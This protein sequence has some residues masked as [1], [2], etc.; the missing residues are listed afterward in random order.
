[1]CCIS[2][3]ND[4][5]PKVCSGIKVIYKVLAVGLSIYL[6]VAAIK[7]YQTYDQRP[8][9]TFLVVGNGTN[10]SNGQN[11]SYYMIR[12]GANITNCS[13]NARFRTDVSAIYYLIVGRT[14]V[15]FVIL[16]VFWFNLSVAIILILLD[17]YKVVRLLVKC[18]PKS[19]KVFEKSYESS[20]KAKESSTIWSVVDAIILKLWLL[21][22]ITAP[23]Y[24]VSAF[25]YSQICLQYQSE[26]DLFAGKFM[27]IAIS[28]P[29]LGL[30]GLC[31]G[32]SCTS[33]IK[34][35]C[36]F[37]CSVRNIIPLIKDPNIGSIQKVCLAYILCQVA[38]TVVFVFLAGGFL[39]VLMLLKPFT[40]GDAIPIVINLFG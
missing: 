20:S 39:C 5:H 17:I 35:E 13:S 11:I 15:N 26:L 28:F 30:I 3:V 27:V 2:D 14:N 33:C 21:T 10:S 23:T 7:R 29:I 36:T 6:I 31:C 16:I 38:Y 25:D 12:T 32:W 34:R 18:V 1:M 9:Y 8:N 24:Y 37:S 19:N 22:T 40:R 4:S